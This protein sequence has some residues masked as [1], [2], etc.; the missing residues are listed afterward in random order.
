[1]TF[2]QTLTQAA[3][4]SIRL[5]KAL[6]EAFDWMEAVGAVQRFDNGEAYA[7]LYA[8]EEM[9]ADGEHSLVSFQK[10]EDFYYDYANAPLEAVKKRLFLFART[11]GD[12]SHS[13]L[14]LDD[15]NKPHFVHIGSGSGSI[16]GGIITDN[17]VDFLR[18]LSVGYIEPA[19]ESCHDKTNLEAW[20]SENGYTLADKAEMIEEGYYTPPITPRAFQAFITETFGTTIPKQGIEIVKHPVPTFD[21][22]VEDPFS[23]WLTEIAG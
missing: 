1:M 3:P 4:P 21:N 2:S 7:G 11:G 22:N 19:F 16:W 6:I 8:A 5:P 15:N 12:G 18:F 20:Y 14:W 17:A 23:L 10:F 13:G 9:S